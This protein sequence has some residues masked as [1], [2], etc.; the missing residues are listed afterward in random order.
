[1]QDLS[2]WKMRRVAIPYSAGFKFSRNLL[3]GKILSYK[4]FFL[5]REAL[6]NSLNKGWGLV[7]L[8]LNSGWN[9]TATNQGW[10]LSSTISAKCFFS[11]S[12]VT[13]SPFAFNLA[14]NLLFNSYLCRCLSIIT[15]ISAFPHNWVHQKSPPSI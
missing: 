3:L 13:K 15:Y 1:M 9:W 2:G 14:R 4:L 11:Y 12:P 5:F 6:M 10:L 8:D 7:G